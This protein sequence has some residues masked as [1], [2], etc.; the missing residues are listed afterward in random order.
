MF[1]GDTAVTQPIYL[2]YFPNL[3]KHF[4]SKVLCLVP[5]DAGTKKAYANKYKPLGTLIRMDA[6]KIQ[7]VYPYQC[8]KIYRQ[9]FVDVGA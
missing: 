4:N 2:R 6:D 8:P 3:N 9:L 1:G 5:D 7:F